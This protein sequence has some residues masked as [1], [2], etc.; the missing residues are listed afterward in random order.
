MKPPLAPAGRQ[1][2]GVQLRVD[3]VCP[4]LRRVQLAPQRDEA[5]LHAGEPR[6]ELA[7]ASSRS[8]VP[9]G[10]VAAGTAEMPS[11]TCIAQAYG[12]RP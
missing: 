4:A 10:S 5:L 11:L 6:P 9:A 2:L 1:S 12:R 7:A 3:C 8:T